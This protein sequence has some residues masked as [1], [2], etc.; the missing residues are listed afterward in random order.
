MRTFWHLI[1]VALANVMA[2]GAWAQIQLPT[3]DQAIDI[4]QRTG[5]PILAMAGRQT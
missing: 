3:L 2:A 5:R 1:A 4:S